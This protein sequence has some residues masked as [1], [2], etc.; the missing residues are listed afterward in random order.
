MKRRERRMLYWVEGDNKEKSQDSRDFGWIRRNMLLGKAKVI[1]KTG[2]FGYSIIME[3]VKGR[4][5]F[6]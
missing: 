4:T 3:R 5:N 2:S 1:H 6:A